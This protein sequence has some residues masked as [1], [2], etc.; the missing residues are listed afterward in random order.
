[1][2]QYVA[3]TFPIQ[4]PAQSD[5]L[6]AFLSAH[7]FDGFEELPDRLTAYALDLNW[8]V[9]TVTSYL[10]EK[11]IPFSQERMEKTNWNW[12]WESNFDPVQVDDFVGIRA[13]FHAPIAGVA[14]ELI[15]TP[16]MSFGTGH[17]ATTR[18]MVQLMRGLIKPNDRVLDFGTG[19][20]LLA[21]LARK[22]GAKEVVGIDI[23]DWSIEN[24]ME[25]AAANNT[26]DIEFICADHITVEGPFD[27]ILAN[28]NRNILLE[29]MGKLQQTLASD[30]TLLMSGILEE[31]MQVIGNAL[32]AEQLCMI[33][34]QSE[35]GWV[36]IQVVHNQ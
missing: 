18:L 24:A 32:Q 17:H 9:D 36:C 16:K 21:I 3:L 7:G 11:S 31:D 26:P 4:S 10:K 20:G 15:V 35:R 33:H 28:I 12:V 30:G 29:H 22:M 34:H 13:H 2:E 23:E 19:T 8:D 27:I 5:E 6:V 14:H 1:M 25:N